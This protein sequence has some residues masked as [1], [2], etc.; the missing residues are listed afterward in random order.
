ME[1]WMRKVSVR[2]GL[3]MVAVAL[4]VAATVPVQAE[5]RVALLIGNN[6]Y[7]D[8]VSLRT[9][10][11]D[12]RTL[13]DVLRKL[14]FSVFVAENV[15]RRSM[16]EAL[17]T[18]DKAIEPGDLAFFFF[19]GHGFEIHGQNYLLPTDVPA[20]SE[21]QEELIR[22]SAFLADRIIERLQARGAR[23]A[24]LVLDAC[25]DNPF[26][27]PGAR[28]IA[29][30][31]GL[32]PMT[33]VEGFFI[34]FSAGAKQIAL[35]GL[36]RNDPNPNSVFTR[37]FARQLSEPGLTLVQVAKRTQAEVKLA[38]A[39]IGHEQTP[40][41]Y[42]QVVGEIVLGLVDKSE[43][44]QVVA[45]P[46]AVA[47]SPP[48]PATANAGGGVLAE[49]DTLAAAGSWR[50]LAA[51]LTE[52]K[53]TAR[54]AH[55]DAL[56]EQAALGELTPL[57]R[58][59]S[60]SVPERLAVLERYYPKFP[61]L[62][63]SRKFLALRD[64]IGR[65]AFA[66][67]FDDARTGPELQKCRDGLEGFVRTLPI[68]VDT[69]R[70]A[71]LLVGLKLNRSAAAWFFAMALE[72][73]GGDRIC[74]EPAVPVAIINALSRPLD[75]PDAKA[76][77][78]LAERCWETVKAPIEENLASESDDSYYVRNL[79]PILTKNNAVTGL[80]ATRC[81]EIGARLDGHNNN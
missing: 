27:R 41:Y 49:L 40:A 62:S 14:N 80:R 9:A 76:G 53:P 61:S 63:S 28:G 31:G 42:D 48:E 70:E 37:S 17:F 7:Q 55:W 74:T 25:R 4:T 77:L 73:P 1:R 46:S 57:A 51:R 5:K 72:A 15:S 11:N 38:A 54:D 50:E 16:S 30:K 23:T 56:V 13:A 79:C 60:T 12:A 10:G 47:K 81:A 34:L 36:S 20:A 66:R 8:V 3:I 59:S 44:A 33:P 22:D 65:E 71:G 21:G 68:T 67:C 26:Q 2:V 39:T 19:A 75:Y 43:A 78:V 24:V 58:P 29:G 6:A 64:T 45:L 69:A 18:F 32:A 52:V 35:D